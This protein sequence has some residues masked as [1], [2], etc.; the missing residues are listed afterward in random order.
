M[1]G[2][3]IV[4]SLYY[5]YFLGFNI[6]LSNTSIARGGSKILKKFLEQQFYVE[7]LV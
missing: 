2:L 7:N 4:E 6:F 3:L 1:S 5:R